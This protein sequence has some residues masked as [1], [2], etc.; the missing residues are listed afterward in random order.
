MK[1]NHIPFIITLAL[2]DLS[3][4]VFTYFCSEVHEDGLTTL[5]YSGFVAGINIIACIILTLFRKKMFFISL[6]NVLFLFYGVNFIAGFAKEMEWRKNNIDYY[7]NI[8]DS[9]FRLTLNKD[10]SEFDIYYEEAGYS[11]G[12]CFGTYTKNDNEDILEVDTSRIG[13]KIP[14]QLIIRNDS[15]FDFKKK[16]MKIKLKKPIF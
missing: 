12:Y 14:Q 10:L 7:I 2:I 3:I 4:L 5:F 13:Y 1:K 8:N 9:V 6:I 11:E 16:G 15:I